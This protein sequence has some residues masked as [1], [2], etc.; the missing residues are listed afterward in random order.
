[1]YDDDDDVTTVLT[2]AR[3]FDWLC[4][5]SW[6]LAGFYYNPPSFSPAI[7]FPGEW[8]RCT[9]TP[10][11]SNLFILAAASL[12]HPPSIL[13]FYYNQRISSWIVSTSCDVNCRAL[14][15]RLPTPT[16]WGAAGLSDFNKYY[17]NGVITF[18]NNNHWNIYGYIYIYIYVLEKHGSSSLVSYF[19]YWF[20]STF[21]IAQT[22]YIFMFDY[23]ENSW[24]FV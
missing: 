22:E 19:A 20:C 24:K 6:M 16:R 21:S 2:R 15:L 13:W 7:I 11:Q 18:T 23:F 9:S 1:M 5:P 3:Y 14:Y 12:F 17:T 10:G 4:Y 8:F